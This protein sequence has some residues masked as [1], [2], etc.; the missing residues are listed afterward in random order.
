MSKKKE[1]IACLIGIRNTISSP[2]EQAI[3]PDDYLY[4]KKLIEN[5]I[6]SLD[7][8]LASDGVYPLN[9]GEKVIR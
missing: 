7:R 4:N 9:K 6:A 1:R 8:L 2:D 3:N 5:V